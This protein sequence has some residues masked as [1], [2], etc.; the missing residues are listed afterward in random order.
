MA[1]PCHAREEAHRSTPLRLAELWRTQI[2]N[3]IASCHLVKLTR[4]I[5]LKSNSFFP[6]RAIGAAALRVTP[7]VLA[8]TF[9]AMALATAP[10]KAEAMPV[11]RSSIAYMV[12]QR[13]GA[14]IVD[15]HSDAIVPIASVSKLMTA[16]VV[17]DTN[18]P[19]SEA[20]EVTDD[21]RDLEKHSSSRLPV[22]AVQTRED[23]LH[24]ALMAS[25]NRAAAAL[26]RYYPGGR[27]GFVAAMNQ[28]ARSLGMADTHFENP[29][30]LSARNVSSA[31]DLVKMVEAAYQYPLIREYSTDPGYRLSTG[32]RGL[33]YHNTNILIRD[34]AWDIGLQK[35]GFINESGICLVMQ[36]TISGRPVVMVLLDSVG[37]HADFMDA[38]RLRAMLAGGEI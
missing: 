22:G 27:A 32:K 24:I 20:I 31:R 14:P 38:S 8:S 2:Q 21:D 30:G 15:K 34:P 10:L 37:R 11:L 23:L 19:L 35:T 1:G 36:T 25:E 28:K 29:T 13:T 12:D 9:T 3:R 26:S 4:E 16:M 6:L 17:L 18:A 7:C 33:S 5:V